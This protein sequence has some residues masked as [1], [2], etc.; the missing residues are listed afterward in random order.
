ML[1]ESFRDAVQETRYYERRAEFDLA[2]A[3]SVEMLVEYGA[4][5]YLG[6]LA[7]AADCLPTLEVLFAFD[8][9]ETHPR[10]EASETSLG[11]M[12]GTLGLILHMLEEAQSAYGEDVFREATA[13]GS[14]E[15]YT[16]YQPADPLRPFLAH[17]QMYQLREYYVYALYALWVHFLYWLRL[18]GPA[19]FQQFR[20]HLNEAVDPAEAAEEVGLVVPSRSLDQWTL[21]DWLT[22]LLDASGV[23]EGNWTERCCAF[24]Q[25]S[26]IP[27]NEHGIYHTLEHTE[28]ADAA[29]Y[30]G[31]SWLTICTLYLRLLGLQETDRWNAWYW[32][33]KGGVRRRSLHLFVRDMSIHSASGDTVLDTLCS[34]YRDSIIAQ[35]TITVLE[36]WRQRNSN[37]FHF[38][39][40][41]GLFDW[42]RD[43]ATGFSAHRFRQAFDMLA[44]LGLYEIDSDAGGSPRLTD[45][46]RATLRRV[47]EACSD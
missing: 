14:C 43:D 40:D 9:D 1:A 45:L 46:G 17:W 8:T 37:T 12:K 24:S 38:V 35:H 30:V 23:S 41:E 4:A 33:R 11:N 10:P 44:D 2:D 28:R 6:G 25:K 39:H 32:A 42:V 29:M 27:L 21:R 3:I 20:T 15:D 26:R 16:P 7:S 19:T 22:E 34:L 5:C 13:F 47:L 36:K 31:L 18:E